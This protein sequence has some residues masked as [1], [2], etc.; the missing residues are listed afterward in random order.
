MLILS[1]IFLYHV[2]LNTEGENV[3]GSRVQE[4]HALTLLA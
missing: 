3:D 1:G 4:K 2:K